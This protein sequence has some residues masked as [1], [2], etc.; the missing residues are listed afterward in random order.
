MAGYVGEFQCRNAMSLQQ[1]HLHT[2]YAGRE[3]ERGVLFVP[4]QELFRLCSSR[5]PYTCV[6]REA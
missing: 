2:H 1:K 3:E 5:R 4:L 6:F